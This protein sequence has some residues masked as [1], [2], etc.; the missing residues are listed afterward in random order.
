MEKPVE[1]V[2]DLVRW[3]RAYDDAKYKTF[4]TRQFKVHVGGK[5]KKNGRDTK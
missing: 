1:V 3:R 5:D 2:D 4:S